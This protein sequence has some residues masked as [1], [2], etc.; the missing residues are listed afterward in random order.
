[1]PPK[2]GASVGNAANTSQA[3]EHGVADDH[4]LSGH[5]DDDIEMGDAPIG[6]D[7]SSASKSAKDASDADSEA[8]DEIIVNVN[9]LRE[10]SVDDTSE[11]TVRAALN[12]DEVLGAASYEEFIFAEPPPASIAFQE[13]GVD[14]ARDEE[15][16]VAVPAKPQT[17]SS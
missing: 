13:E 5:D 8:E 6:S 2:A 16:S 14:D 10:G 3:T 11:R 4:T 12:M 17:S 7:D 1:M 9:K 15:T